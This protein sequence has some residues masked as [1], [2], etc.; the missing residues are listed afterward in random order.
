MNCAPASV[1][2]AA[3]SGVSTVPAPT[4]IPGTSAAT[5]RIASTPAA[6][7]RVIS[8]TPMP[9]RRSA[10]A[11][12]TAVATSSTTTTGMTGEMSSTSVPERIS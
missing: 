2:A 4:T 7:R 11:S 3:S 8:M 10:V 1:T 5:A 12:G 9:P 6:V